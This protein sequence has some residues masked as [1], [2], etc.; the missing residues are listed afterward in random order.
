MGSVFFKAKEKSENNLEILKSRMLGSFPDT[1]I[2]SSNICVYACGSLGRLEMTHKTDL[3]LFFIALNDSDKESKEIYSNVNR[4][5]FFSNLYSIN[6][7]LG[8]HEPSK[9]GDYWV[10]TPKCNLLDIGSRQEDYN[11]SF[12]ARMLL[13]LESKP[14]FNESGYRELLKEVIEKYFV[15]YKDYKSRFYPLYLMND[16]MRYWYTLTLNYEYRRDGGDDANEKSWKRLK[17][18][19]AR[20]ITCFS[21]IACLY[22]KSITPEDVMNYTQMTPFERLWS[23]SDTITD[24]KGIIS[25]IENEY[26]WFIS[27][28]DEKAEWWDI[29][30]NRTNAINKAD[31]FHKLVFCDLMRVVS[32][33]NPA[34]RQKM[35][36]Y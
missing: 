30:D 4:Y 18:K 9:H 20:L 10:F 36:V 8:Y 16:I 11:N 28:R 24:I 13:I 31:Y 17:L 34:L 35:D 7:E 29:A 33:S 27:L 6:K 3:D 23:L 15:D 26:E 25:K 1:D 12:T 21:M 14:I 32:G 5:L 19:Y 2:L 22:K